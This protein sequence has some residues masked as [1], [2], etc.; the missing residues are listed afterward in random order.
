MNKLILS[1][2]RA[3][4]L[5]LLLLALSVK[6]A[7]NNALFARFGGMLYAAMLVF[8]TFALALLARHLSNRNSTDAYGDKWIDKLKD[9]TPVGD[10]ARDFHA[11]PPLEKVRLTIV[12]FVGYLLAV[13][14]L[15]HVLVK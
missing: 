12:Q 7:L 5:L 13:A 3:H 1:Y 6:L 11:L 9:G 15:L 8:A 2:L 4:W 14:I 10:F